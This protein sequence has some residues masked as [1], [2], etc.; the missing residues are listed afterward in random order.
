MRAFHPAAYF[1]FDGER[2]R[3]LAVEMIEDAGAPGLV[4]DDR[5][6]IACLEGAIRPTLVQRAGRGVMT[7]QEMLRGF[8]IPAGTQL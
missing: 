7:A 1:E 3:V 2:V 8:A 5:L 6:T 4:L